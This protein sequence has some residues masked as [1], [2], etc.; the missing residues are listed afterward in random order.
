MVDSYDEIDNG[1]DD[2][3]G[4][5][6][7]WHC[8]IYSWK[9]SVNDKNM[10]IQ[11]FIIERIIYF[12]FRVNLAKVWANAKEIMRINNKLGEHS[13]QLE[14][15][16]TNR[17]FVDFFRS[18]L[19]PHRHNSL[20]NRHKLFNRQITIYVREKPSV[21]RKDLACAGSLMITQPSS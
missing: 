2:G 21:E 18:K 14:W 11:F 15:L 8:F 12:R 5:K 20:G 19:S 3:D 7:M 13:N 9:P 17:C 4:E 16:R 1:A 10:K 6:Y